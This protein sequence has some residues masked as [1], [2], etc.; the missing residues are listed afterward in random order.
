M[1]VGLKVQVD[2]GLVLFQVGDVAGGGENQIGFSTA[3]AKYLD[4]L[5]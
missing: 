1:V 3:I 2:G 5:K 4:V